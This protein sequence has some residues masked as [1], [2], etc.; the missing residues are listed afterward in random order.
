MVTD[1]PEGYSPVARIHDASGGPRGIRRSSVWSTTCSAC[2]RTRQGRP[3]GPVRVAQDAEGV[4]GVRCD[5]DGIEPLGE[6][7]SV[8]IV[9][10]AASLLTA[11]TASPGAPRPREGPP[12]SAPRTPGT[13]ATVANAV[14]AQADQAVVVEEWS[15]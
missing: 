10:P 4:V 14:P 15:R 9:T 7:P 5:H 12:R 11:A 2:N 1:A 6:P 8:W 13:A 3:L